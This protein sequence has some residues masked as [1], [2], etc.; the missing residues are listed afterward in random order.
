MIPWLAVVGSYTDHQECTQV[1]TK[2]RG[3]KPYLYLFLATAKPRV[4]KKTSSG[5]CI[6]SHH[7]VNKKNN[8]S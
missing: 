7:G 4:N 3:V 5:V 2:N 8:S 1:C 6:G